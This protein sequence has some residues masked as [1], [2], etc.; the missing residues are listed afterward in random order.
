MTDQAGEAV[1][2]TDEEITRKVIDIV[3]EQTMIESKEVTLQSTPD[4]LGIDSLGLVEI[5]FA[6]EETFDVTVPYNANEPT[7]SDFDL[8]TVGA[9]VT[10][11]KRLI[12]EQ[13]GQAVT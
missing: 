4:E 12:Q 11:V 7:N 10:A 5:V 3:A 8:S 1:K 9:V 6:I 13:S 2:F